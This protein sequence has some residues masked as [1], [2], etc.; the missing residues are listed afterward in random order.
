MPDSHR[1]LSTLRIAVTRAEAQAEGLAEQ[2]R[3]L[4]AS[5]LI[6]PLIAIAPP[7]DTAALDRALAQL[8]SYD[9][10]LLTSANGVAALVERLRETG[11]APAALAR[12]R[13]G[14]VG[15]ATAAA[16]QRYNLRADLVPERHDAEGLLSALAAHEPLSGRRVLLAQAD[17]ARPALA[18]GLRARGAVVDA[19]VAYRTVPGP[20]ADQLA[21]A[22]RR[23]ALDVLTLTSPSGVRAVMDALG[24]T[25]LTQREALALF[26]RV[27]VACIGPVT[28]QA[29]ERLGLRVDVVP[30]QY[31]TEGLVAALIQAVTRKL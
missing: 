18:D 31:T 12:M 23:G 27:L 30:E 8:G 21:Q 24:R 22:L 29:A 17:I 15:P 28:A 2:L 7:A 13:I 26:D 20:G 14:V 10:L 19:L 9:W 4:G 16:L 5:V 1:P 11:A 6:C 3:A 25:E